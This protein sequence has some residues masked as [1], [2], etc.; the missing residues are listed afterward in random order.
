MPIHIEDL[1]FIKS[2]KFLMNNRK[3]S[4]YILNNNMFN[5]LVFI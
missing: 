4:I 3:D 1:R 2:S 5:Y